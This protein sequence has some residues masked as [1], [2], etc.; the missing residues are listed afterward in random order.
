M[1]KRAAGFTLVEL[2]IVVI[3][4]GIIMSFAIPAY[5]AFLD[6]AKEG[7]GYDLIR[8]GLKAAY[9]YYQTDSAWPGSLA[10]TEA[11]SSQV[12]Y[13]ASLG[14]DA[15]NQTGA[16]KPTPPSGQTLSDINIALRTLSLGHGSD[17]KIRGWID[18][19]G[20]VYL[21]VDRPDGTNDNWQSV[22]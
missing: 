20:T 14:I 8:K 4:I 3:A 19:V 16:L 1:R 18:N 15:T 5:N 12:K 13:W 22:G 7:E 9:L 2:L 10:E 6:R 21:E 11:P 17:H